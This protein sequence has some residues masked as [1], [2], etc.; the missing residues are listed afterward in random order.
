MNLGAIAAQARWPALA[1]GG[2]GFWLPLNGASDAGRVDSVFMLIMWVC[3]FF[4]ALIVALMTY[5][6]IKY[7]RAPGAM[8]EEA[9]HH[10][11]LLEAVWS[12][13]PFILVIVIF[14]LGF[15]SFL[16]MATPPQNSYEIQVTAQKWQWLFTYP[17]GWVD[18]ELHVPQDQP[19]KLV[20]TS[21]DVIHSF[22]V[23]DFRV[24]KDVVPGRYTKVW[25]N[26]TVPGEHWLFCTEYCGTGHSDMITR[27][28]VHPPGE[29]EKWLET[30]ANVYKT[31]PPAQAGAEMYKKYGCVQCHS[32]DGKA[33]TGPS[34]KGLFGHNVQLA[35]GSTLA[36]D[37]TY[38]RESILDPQAQLVAGYQGVMPT[39]KGKVSDEQIG[40]IIE[41]L[42]TLGAE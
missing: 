4:F 42:K 2:Q 23:P 14:S 3:V 10:N 17:N 30:A 20:M 32:T 31:M 9:P 38:I 41:Y 39:F 35:D 18:K 15:R 28:V 24:K 21:Q 19:V 8:A 11:N 6:V 7:R 36:V 16:A 33:G 25:F 40:W 5:F 29:F 34:F 26:A 27:V 1:D 12:G 22:F 37:E 13:I